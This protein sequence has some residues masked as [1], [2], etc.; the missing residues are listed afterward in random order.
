MEWL[1]KK[2]KKKAI[3]VTMPMSTVTSAGTVP[4]LSGRGPMFFLAPHI[5][6]DTF[7]FIE[8]KEGYTKY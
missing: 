7:F 1:L 6:K 5:S 4:N 8:K 2:K 3:H